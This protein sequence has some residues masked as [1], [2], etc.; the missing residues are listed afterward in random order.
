MF[1][2][3]QTCWAVTV[4]NSFSFQY[5][6]VLILTFNNPIH[7]MVSILIILRVLITILSNLMYSLSCY[8]AKITISVNSNYIVHE[9][10]KRNRENIAS[11]S[12]IS[13]LYLTKKHSS[14]SIL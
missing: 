6:W 14:I 11:D 8:G 10:I 5:I 3:E 7:T 13:R 1:M 9:Y 4:N 12:L 2:N